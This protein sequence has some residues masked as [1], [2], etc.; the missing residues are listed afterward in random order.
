MV[1]TDGEGKVSV[2]DHYVVCAICTGG[3]TAR[4]NSNI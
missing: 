2:S 1:E 4:R 3:G